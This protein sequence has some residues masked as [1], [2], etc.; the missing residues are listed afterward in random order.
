MSYAYKIWKKNMAATIIS[1]DYFKVILVT[2]MVS[3]Y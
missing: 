3:L 2:K 1:G